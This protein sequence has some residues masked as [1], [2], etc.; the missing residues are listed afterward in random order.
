MTI[1]R[2]KCLIFCLSN[3]I[4]GGSALITLNLGLKSGYK[5]KQI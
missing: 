3:C 1:I 2:V 4:N 5:Y